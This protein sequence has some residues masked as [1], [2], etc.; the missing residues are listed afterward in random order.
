MN[1]LFFALAFVLAGIEWAAEVKKRQRVIY[2]C[3][4]GVMIALLIWVFM[5]GGFSGA[6]L[7]FVLGLF[8][9]L[10]GDV[11]LMLPSNQFIP[12]LIA[13][14]I[15]HLCYIAG[16]NQSPPALNLPNLILAILI[17]ITLAL[18][19]RR[20]SAE[21]SARR[22]ERLIRPVLVYAIVI[23]VMLFSAL[24]TLTSPEWKAT[25]ALLVA[26]GAML[27][28]IS[29]MLLAWNKFVGPTPHGRLMNISAYHLGQMLLVLGAAVQYLV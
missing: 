23:S 25:Q 2:I 4:P 20:I 27:F 7:W 13:F 26:A 19:I 29:D 5:N 15:A 16:L 12:G 11:L 24:A 21:L 9:S 17:I 6:M 28:Y 10:A 18:F 8:F 14:L 22:L 3:K 1:Y